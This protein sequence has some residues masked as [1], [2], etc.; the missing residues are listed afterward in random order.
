VEAGTLID[1]IIDQSLSS[2]TNR[3]GDRFDAS[4]ASPV[5]VG[6]RVAIPAGAKASGTF[7]EAESAGRVRGSA[8]LEMK[9][10][11]VTVCGLT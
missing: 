1:V 11:S 2:E 4:V 8:A 3:P 7:T 10:D 9:L 5:I 6:D